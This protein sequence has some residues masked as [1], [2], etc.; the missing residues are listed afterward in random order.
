MEL[1]I[2]ERGSS[3]AINMYPFIK[4]RVPISI[5][6]S[7]I[8]EEGLVVQIGHIPESF[9]TYSYQ[10]YVRLPKDLYS[11]LGKPITVEIFEVKKNLFQITKCR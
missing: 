11:M 7:E 3:K 1:K 4:G 6:F 2:V 10:N 9:N 5:K 8:G